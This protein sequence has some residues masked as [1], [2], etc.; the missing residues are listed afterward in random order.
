MVSPQEVATL[1]SFQAFT[2]CYLREVESGKWHSVREFRERA[3]LSW[4]PD[5]A[6][7]IELTLPLPGH[8][9]ALGVSYRSLVG[10]HTLRE[11]YLR[12]GPG[13]SY[14]A[15]DPLSAELVLIDA[16]YA[17]APHLPER[18]ELLGRVV[19]SHQVM[20]RYLAHAAEARKGAPDAPFGRSFIE[21]EQSALYGHWLHPMPKSRQGIATWQH[22]H[23]SPELHGRFQLH[24]FAVAR[25]L[26]EQESIAD[27]PAEE[28][29]RNL[30]LRGLDCG[31]VERLLGSL[32]DLCLIPVHPLQAE[33]LIQKS[34]VRRL[35]A[36]GALRDLGPLG[37]LFTAT[38][39]VRTVYSESFEYMMKLSIPVKITN[40][41][42]INL[43][44]ELGDS[45][46]ISELLRRCRVEESFTELAI[47]EDPACITVAIPELEETGFEV[48]FRKNP[49]TGAGSRTDLG[50]PPGRFAEP[51][52]VTALTSDPL[53]GETR[54]LLEFFVR[55]AS[56]NLGLPLF[57]AALR[58]FEAYFLCVIEPAL[59]IYDRWGIALEAH[60]QNSLVAFDDVGLPKSF[61]YR[62][63]QGLALSE[64][65][66]D[67]LTCLVPQL[68]DQE[69]VFEPDDIVQNG[70]IY[71]L[72]FNH[73]YPVIHRL[74]VDGLS[75]EATLLKVVWQR[76]S[77]MRLRLGGLGQTL[78]DHLLTSPEL[79]CKANL[80]T[81]VEDRDE[82]Q[83]DQELAV[84]S[85]IA[86]PLVQFGPRVARRNEERK[87]APEPYCEPAAFGTNT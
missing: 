52:A 72:F 37:P 81:R 18:L 70:L 86:N 2:G 22:E 28:L 56:T 25:H 3:R 59:G 57:E 38:S 61:Y 33:W 60:Q 63:I 82:L 29:S 15:I 83:A 44:S 36:Q 49:F 4:S 79:P 21:S 65:R 67:K 27:R 14:S 53:P 1:A 87:P 48:I 74:G 5:V 51:H 24:F 46:W 35:V 12:R 80:L 66:R 45:V 19:E 75:E 43:K 69:K 10:R 8:S 31:R 7:V 20:A 64:S 40:S 55:R 42:R 50:G 41:L 73:L 16:I 32:G 11:I 34:H 23:F 85:M 47:L 6:H 58:W 13:E 26:V 62:D 76:L 17:R 84:Y 78:I 9:L 71:Y 77:E 39:S 30:A 54:S 68:E